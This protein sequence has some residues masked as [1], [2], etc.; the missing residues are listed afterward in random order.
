[1]ENRIAERLGVGGIK[2]RRRIATYGMCEVAVAGQDGTPKL[3]RLDISAAER[4]EQRRQCYGVDVPDTFFSGSIGVGMMFRPTEQ[5]GFRVE[6]RA[7]GTLLSSS[8]KI[9]CSTGPD[10]NICAVQVD[11]DLLSQVETFAGITFRF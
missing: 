11:G 5:I 2:V 10:L 6:A 4:F 7:Y 9:F 1:M 8:S 3:H